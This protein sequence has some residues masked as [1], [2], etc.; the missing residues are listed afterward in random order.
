MTSIYSNREAWLASGFFLAFLVGENA[1]LGDQFPYRV[2][3][4][5]VRFL[6]LLCL[7]SS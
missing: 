1:E 4:Y 6:A 7:F 5:S 2:V 3:V